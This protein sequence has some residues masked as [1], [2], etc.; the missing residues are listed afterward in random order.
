MV[1]KNSLKITLSRGKVSLKSFMYD[2]AVLL[3][4]CAVLIAVLIP[5]YSAVAD[6][7]AGIGLLDKFTELFTKYNA[8]TP[9]AGEEVLTNFVDAVTKAFNIFVSKFLVHSI[10]IIFVAVII[11]R[12]LFALKTVP[13]MDVVNSFMSTNGEYEFGSNFLHNLKLSFKYSLVYALVSLPFD[14]L[15]CLYVLYGIT[16]TFNLMGILGSAVVVAVV[17]LMFALRRVFLNKWVPALLMN[18]GKVWP[19]LWESVCDGARHFL[20][21]LWQFFAYYALAWSLIVILAVTSFGVAALVIFPII[22]LYSKVYDLV[23]YYESK[24]MRYYSEVGE[25]VVPQNY[26]D[27]EKV[28]E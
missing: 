25:V 9:E 4:I 26:V 18:G 19:A 21:R 2:I 23:S 22:G 16:F 5:A 1:T 28:A 7:I 13:T 20:S 14:V 6:E 12:I 8:V 3:V 15:L 24:G 11:M 27:E 17:V 10:I